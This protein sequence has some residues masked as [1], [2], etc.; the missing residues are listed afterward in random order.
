VYWRRGG[1]DSGAIGKVN[2]S[3]SF[4]TKCLAWSLAVLVLPFNLY[5]STVAT[6]W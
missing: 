6:A 2:A 5:K 1:G 3:K 4:D